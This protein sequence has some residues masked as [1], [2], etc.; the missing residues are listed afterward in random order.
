MQL[1][2]FQS[3]VAFFFSKIRFTE[4]S[5]TKRNSLENISGNRACER[6]SASKKI[7]KSTKCRKCISNVPS[8]FCETKTIY[9][10]CETLH[11]RLHFSA[12]MTIVAV[13]QLKRDVERKQRMQREKTNV[14]EWEDAV[15]TCWCR[16]RACLP[17]NYRIIFIQIEMSEINF[18]NEWYLLCLDIRHAN[19]RIFIF[20]F[21]EE[22]WRTVRHIGWNLGFRRTEDLPKR[23]CHIVQC[24]VV[25]THVDAIYM[26][27]EMMPRSEYHQTKK[28]R[29][30]GHQIIYRKRCVTLLFGYHFKHCHKW[31]PFIQIWLTVKLGGIFGCTK[32]VC[33]ENNALFN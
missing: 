2:L 27:L 8:S 20:F 11:L 28:H 29:H 23:L 30:Y 4:R 33:F 24:V 7:V 1:Q 25:H 32:K 6:T 10:R 12:L 19:R 26:L 14:N 13:Q 3:M 9:F 31:A 16:Y 17:F 18:P 5:S 15:T 22:F 21:S